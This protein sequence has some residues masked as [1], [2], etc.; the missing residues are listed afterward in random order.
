MDREVSGLIELTAGR[1]LPKTQ[2]SR[3]RK[4]YFGGALRPQHTDL[5]GPKWKWMGI[6][7]PPPL[8]RGTVLS[9]PFPVYR[10]V[11]FPPVLDTG[12][13]GRRLR[14]VALLVFR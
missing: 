10:D 8:G 2:P 9:T 6:H 4:T 7:S 5:M 13:R 14:V 11:S 1:L 3:L 12:L